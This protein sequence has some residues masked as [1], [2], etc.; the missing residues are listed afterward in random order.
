MI[1]IAYRDRYWTK[2]Y[3]D[4]L[5]VIRDASEQEGL[6]MIQIALHWLLQYSFL[7]S[8]RGDGVILAAS[9]LKQWETNLN[10]LDGELSVKVLE[11]I[12]RACERAR[13]DCPLYFRA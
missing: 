7:K 12:D 2:G 13:R 1:K 6:P 11:A 9:N 4:A 3:F 8:S 10:S 5:E